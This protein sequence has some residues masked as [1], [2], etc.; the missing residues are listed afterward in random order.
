MVYPVTVDE[1][2]AH[3]R[4]DGD[5][6]DELQSYIAAATEHIQRACGIQLCSA[7]YQLTLDDFPNSRIIRF[8]VPPLQS[9]E[10]VTYHGIDGWQAT[11][12]PSSYTVDTATRPGRLML[13]TDQVWPLVNPNANAVRVNFTAGYGEPNDVPFLLKQA[14]KFLVGGY[15]EN[16]ESLIS[17][18]I[19]NEVPLAV[20]S[21]VDMF[22]FVEVV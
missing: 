11:L 8:P 20:Q 1:A 6:P 4:I 22:K 7:S 3:L 10:S 13:N 5:A 14:I 18:T 21:I 17:G 15:F 12:D 9:V 19:I 2:V 16:R